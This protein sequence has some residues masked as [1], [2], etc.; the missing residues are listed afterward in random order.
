MEIFLEKLSTCP[1]RQPSTTFGLKL[2]EQIYECVGYVT[3]IDKLYRELG[4]SFDE[5]YSSGDDI[6]IIHCISTSK[7]ECNPLT[8]NIV[9]KVYLRIEGKCI[10][11]KGDYYRFYV[12]GKATT[13]KI[14]RNIFD[15]FPTTEWTIEKIR[16]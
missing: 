10:T 14:P 12:D 9:Q 6:T 4:R 8:G 3:G 7:Q 11:T 1:S 5:H 2:A 13:K 16:I 15:I